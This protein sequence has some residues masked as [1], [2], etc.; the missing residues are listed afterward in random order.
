[1]GDPLE[2]S[3]VDP[4]PDGRKDPGIRGWYETRTR[5]SRRFLYGSM[6][7][8]ALGAALFWMLAPFSLSQHLQTFNGAVLIPLAGGIWIA[9]FILVW[10]VPMRELSFRGQESLERSE[11]RIRAF[12]EDE[13]G[14]AIETWRR[15]GERIEKETA[16]GFL[17]EARDAFAA[18]RAMGA[19]KGP[20]PD[21][22]LMRIVRRAPPVAAPAR[23]HDAVKEA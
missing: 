15:I 21:P 7:L 9:A 10:L 18:V 6:A 22:D 5:A 14:P 13:A 19:P 2:K 12:L 17:E 4:E 16:A 20:P 23:N 1:M 11:E 8:G 3:R